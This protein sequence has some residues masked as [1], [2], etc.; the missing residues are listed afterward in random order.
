AAVNVGAAGS[1]KRSLRDEQEHPGGESGSV[2]VDDAAGQGRVKD[3]GEIVGARE[4][5]EDG[6]EHE[7]DHRG[8]EEMVVAAAGKLRRRARGASRRSDGCGQVASV[9]RK[10]GDIL[11]RFGKQVS[12]EV[13][14]GGASGVY[15]GGCDLAGRA[16]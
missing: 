14:A 5:E 8:E 6:G 10:V 12:Y 3:A 15:R 9:G 1:D 16:W 11:Y 2:D 7:R 4:A 13:I